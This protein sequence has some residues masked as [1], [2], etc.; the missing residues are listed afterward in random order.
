MKQYPMAIY[1]CDVCPFWIKSC[2]HPHKP[3]DYYKTE[4]V[5]SCWGRNIPDWCPLDDYNKGEGK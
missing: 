4:P 3:D 5:E 1:V 2:G